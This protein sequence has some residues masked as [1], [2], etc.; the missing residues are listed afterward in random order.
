MA[1]RRYYNPFLS[2]VLILA[3]CQVNPLILYLNVFIGVKET[4]LETIIDHCSSDHRTKTL[5]YRQ[6]ILHEPMGNEVNL[7]Y[8]SAHKM[9]SITKI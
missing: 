4:C 9:Y 1:E 5:K 3:L 6:L 2:L 8:V 7:V